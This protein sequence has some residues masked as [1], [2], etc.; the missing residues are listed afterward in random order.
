MYEFTRLFRKNPLEMAEDMIKCKK[1]TSQMR[2]EEA[3]MAVKYSIPLSQIVDE[4]S[5]E[6]S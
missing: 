3:Y 2:T 6:K 5:F 4:F 1:G